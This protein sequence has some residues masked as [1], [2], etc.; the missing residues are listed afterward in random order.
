MLLFSPSALC[1]SHAADDTASVSGESEAHAGQQEGVDAIHHV[2]D[3][4]VI[5]V[6]WPNEHLAKEIH[7][8][9]LGAYTVA[10]IRFDMAVTKHVVFLWISGTILLIIV[11][12][13]AQKVRGTDPPRGIHNLVETFVVF[14]RDE[15]TVPTMGSRYG[16]LLLPH[17]LSVFFFILTCNLMGLLPYAATATGNI[18]VTAGLAILSFLLIQ[19]VAVREQGLLG[20]FKHLTGGVHWLLWP[21][22]LPVEIMGLF[23]KPFALCIRLFANMTS[24]HIV[25]LS[26]L[27]LIFIFR[28]VAVAG[29]AVPFSLFVYLLEILVAFLQAY[30]F[31]MLTCVFTGLGVHA[32]HVEGEEHPQSP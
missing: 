17:M 23:T 7:L 16:R 5:E 22:M 32:D 19:G 11:A 8:P 25:I 14:I 4:R 1:A 24:G 18:S 31:T 10:G 9:S 20:W 13:A 12:V 28:S 26:I 29:L 2:M 21:I 15:V 27:S 3:S 6:P 30:I